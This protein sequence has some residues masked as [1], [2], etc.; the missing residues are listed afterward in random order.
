MNDP[1]LPPTAGFGRANNLSSA[2]RLRQSQGNTATGGSGYARH[3]PPHRNT[4]NQR[5]GTHQHHQ[6]H[7]QQQQP[8]AVPKPMDDDFSEDEFKDE[9]ID[10][11]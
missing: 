7:H 2:L 11:R 5:P 1:L 6:H 9:D 10:N 3:L 8:M 4:M